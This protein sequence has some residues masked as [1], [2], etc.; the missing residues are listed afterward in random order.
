MN[1]KIKRAIFD[2]NKID[3]STHIH[4]R[5]HI[6]QK[7]CETGKQISYTVHKVELKK[8]PEQKL[9]SEQRRLSFRF[10]TIRYET[11]T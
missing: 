10:D 6:E 3:T 2:R 5:T 4:I 9:F 1:E 11:D 7:E 8:K